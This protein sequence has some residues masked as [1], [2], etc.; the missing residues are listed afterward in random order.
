ME[1]DDR[2]R[3]VAQRRTTLVSIGAAAALVALKLGV[4][5]AA[6][7]LA[8]I[9][10]GV[11]S[12]GDVLA[13]V[14]T[15]FAVRLGRQPADREHPYGHAR[16]EN[17][18]ALGES[19]IL[20]AA[21]VALAAAAIA[22]L[23]SP[24]SAP[25]TRWFVF[26]TIAVALLVD[27]ARTVVSART[28]RRFASPALRSNAFHF[29]ADATGSLLV[30]AALVAVRAGFAAADPI[31]AL[32]IAVLVLGAA[33]RLIAE[34]ANVLMD[35]APADAR[36]VAT[37]ALAA[38]EPDIELTRLRLRESAGRFFA[39]AN[40][41]VAAGQVVAEGH[42]AAGL[43]EQAIQ[44]ALPGSD[45][46]VH[47]EPRREN[48]DLRDR[49]LAIALSEPAVR[50]VHDVKLYEQEQG[51]AVTL[52]LKLPHDCALVEAQAVS[53]RIERAILA[54]PRVASVQTHLEPLERPVA[55]RRPAGAGE[56]ADAERVAELAQE[57]SGG[58]LVAARVL[59]TDAGRVVLLT[60]AMD[61]QESLLEAHRVA[62]EL[63]EALRARLEDVLDVVVH[64]GV[65]E[66]PTA[67]IEPATPRLQGERS[68]S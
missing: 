22:R 11:E 2:E 64:T 30:L 45:V 57:L 14:L 43:V 35:R 23:I 56:L 16:A 13:A 63:E 44:R 39:D 53:A 8:L 42:R 37:R 10:A 61:E 51:V 47:V 46:V 60:L 7:S 21:G 58:R 19:G 59:R 18:G 1:P 12:S 17:L 28:A 48:L 67:G 20:L 65:K 49:V 62:S 3:A 31:A 5:V 55:A 32:A 15:F 26:A 41:S 52:H 29:A 50:E 36:A 25:D 33:L 24:G 6:G 54:R 9:S 66:E 38:L 40:V 4:G 27:L 68:A 34:N